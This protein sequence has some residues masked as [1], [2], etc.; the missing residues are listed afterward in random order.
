MSIM[1]TV[2]LIYE[3]RFSGHDYTSVGYVAYLGLC[4]NV[5]KYRKYHCIPGN[6][7]YSRVLPCLVQEANFYVYIRIS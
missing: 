1:L 4:G 3:L 2:S 7:N 6:R 5:L